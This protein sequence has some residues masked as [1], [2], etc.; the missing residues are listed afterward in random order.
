MRSDLLFSLSKITI[1]RVGKER[2]VYHIMSV[3][4]TMG[5][6]ALFG[7]RDE[8]QSSIEAAQRSALSLIKSRRYMACAPRMTTC[9]NPNF[10]Y[11]VRRAAHWLGYPS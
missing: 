5:E 3:L 6:I 10:A 4:K 1:A 8:K 11:A 2:D 9:F 7:V